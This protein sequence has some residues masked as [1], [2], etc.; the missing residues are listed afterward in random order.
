MNKC[1][2]PLKAKG[3]HSA[4][5]KLNVLRLTERERQEYERYQDNLHYEASIIASQKIEGYTEGHAE[6]R[7]KGHVEGHAEGHAEGHSEGS[8]EKARGIALSLKKAG[9]SVAEISQHTGLLK[10]KLKSCNWHVLR[11]IKWDGLTDC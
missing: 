3:I 1:N 8:S 10:R 11:I 5:E 4:A 6:G 9:L 2:P 7:A